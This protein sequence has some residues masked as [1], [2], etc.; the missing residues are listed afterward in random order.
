MCLLAFSTL[1]YYSLVI[2]HCYIVRENSLVEF[3]SLVYVFRFL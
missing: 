1:R 2:L 3:Y